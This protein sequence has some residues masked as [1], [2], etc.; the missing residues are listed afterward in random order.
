MHHEQALNE[1]L[2]AAQLSKKVRAFKSVKMHTDE[3]LLEEQIEKE[4]YLFSCIFAA[5]NSMM[6]LAD[7]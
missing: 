6:Q 3:T 1:V 4:V 2:G 5:K 7:H